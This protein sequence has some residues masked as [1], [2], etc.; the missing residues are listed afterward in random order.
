MSLYENRPAP[1]ADEPI[2]D[3]LVGEGLVWIDRSVHPMRARLTR[4][5]REVAAGE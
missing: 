1:L 2:W 3:Y 4:H 5:G